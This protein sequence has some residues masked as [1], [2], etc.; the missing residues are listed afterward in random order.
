MTKEQLARLIQEV[1]LGHL[2]DNIMAAGRP[3]LRF[4]L[5]P[6]DE[7][8]VPVGATKFGGR[9][10]L[11]PGVEW[12][13][14]QGYP[15][16]DRQRYPPGEFATEDGAQDFLLQLRLEDVAGYD[17]DGVLPK[18]GILYF[19]CATWKAALGHDDTDRDCWKVLYYDGDLSQLTRR[20]PPP[21]YPAGTGY[22][23]DPLPCCRVEFLPDF[24]LPDSNDPVTFNPL[25]IAWDSGSDETEYMRYVKLTELSDEPDPREGLRYSEPRNRL[26]GLPQIVQ[27]DRNIRG[28]YDPG[29]GQEWCLL[30]QLDSDESV[31]LSWQG[32]GRGYFYIPVQ[33]LAERNFDAV[34]VDMQCT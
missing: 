11:P 30:L 23:N 28:D 6:T 24:V 34:W 2:E 4:H 19:L 26:L 14:W 22:G 21:E 5:Y 12:P 18:T 31:G 1:G 3:S 17:L 33:A 32:A 9:P 13:V 8:A 29:S 15:E 25:G 7:D 20:L 16:S 27:Y 10:D